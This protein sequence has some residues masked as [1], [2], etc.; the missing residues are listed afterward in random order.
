VTR[1]NHGLQTLEEEEEDEEEE[2]E[3]EEDENKMMM[4][5]THK[6]NEIHMTASEIP[7]TKENFESGD[8]KIPLDAD[9]S[10][11]LSFSSYILSVFTQKH[12]WNPSCMTSWNTVFKATTSVASFR[13]NGWSYIWRMR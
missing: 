4:M 5:Y 3:E 9:A 2:D 13:S 7:R 1:V 11:L 12:F 8:I 10:K 6:Q